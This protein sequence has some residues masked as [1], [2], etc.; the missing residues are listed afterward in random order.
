MLDWAH[1]LTLQAVADGDADPCPALDDLVAAGL[2]TSEGQITPHGRAALAA[3][4][5]SRGERL[6]LRVAVASAAVFAIASVIELFV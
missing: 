3:S 1:G 5:S 6:A 4:T 2:V